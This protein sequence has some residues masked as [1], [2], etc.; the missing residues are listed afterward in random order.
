MLHDTAQ[1]S[2]VLNTG[3]SQTVTRIL[4]AAATCFGRSGFFGTSMQDIASEARVSKSLLHYHFASKEHLLLD[5]QL[6]LVRQLLDQVRR[7]SAGAQGSWDQLRLALDEVLQFLERESESLGVL[8]DLRHVMRSN[9]SLAER[10]HTFHHD[11]DELVVIGINAVLGPA[12]GQLQVSPDRLARLLRLLFHGV[13]A[14]LSIATGDEARKIV[15]ETFS[16]FETLLFHTFVAQ[17][18][19]KDDVRDNHAAI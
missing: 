6:M 18:S 17:T 3:P 10:I 9:P 11:V 2:D 5:V 7:L 12:V 19:N 13:I 1:S 15:R 8:L 16:D 4:T 14:E